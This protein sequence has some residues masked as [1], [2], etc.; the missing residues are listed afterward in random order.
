MNW[1][2]ALSVRCLVIYRF[3]SVLW[4]RNPTCAI[5]FSRIGGSEFILLLQHIVSYETFPL[6][7]CVGTQFINCSYF[8]FSICFLLPLYPGT[9]VLSRHAY[10]QYAYAFCVVHLNN[11]HRL[12]GCSVS[13]P[14][15]DLLIDFI[16]LAELTFSWDHNN[17]NNLR[18]SGKHQWV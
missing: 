16:F 15:I 7:S 4:P 14:Q 8:I 18:M 11:E 1:A 6:P 10:P 3:V 5:V 9:S 17:Y 12:Q 13:V 2:W